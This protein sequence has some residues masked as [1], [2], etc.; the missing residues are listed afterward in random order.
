[1]SEP[2]VEQIPPAD[3]QRTERRDPWARLTRGFA[4]FIA[5]G[6]LVLASALGALLATGFAF[7]LA[8]ARLAGALLLAVLLVNGTSAVVKG[9]INRRRPGR[10]RLVV[11]PIHLAVLVIVALFTQWIGA[12][13][14]VIF[15]LLLVVPEPFEA[16]RSQTGQA[17]TEVP[18]GRRLGAVAVLV[19]AGWALVMGIAAAVGA[20]YIAGHPFADLI[21]WE[22]IDAARA[23]ELQT[24]MDLATILGLEVC[25]AVVVIA[26][27]SLPVL[28]LPL[29]GFEGRLLWDWSP[30]A[31]AI[32]YV[33]V[34]AAA[35]IMLLPL[36]QARSVWLWG[37]PFAVYA[38]AVLAIGLGRRRRGAAA[39]V[40]SQPT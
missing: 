38:V 23:P 32:G 9:L 35:S 19:G 26:F 29:R 1:M 4:G 37:I 18:G 31:W 16:E 8:T 13:A 27:G 15:G 12:G 24:A 25:M 33:V 10:P 30:I 21:S 22:Q 36:V 17:G 6:L 11:R 5:F 3:A 39:G 40:T 7:T 28:L 14:V 2:I 34:S 20:A